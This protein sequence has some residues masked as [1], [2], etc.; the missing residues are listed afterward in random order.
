MANGT[1]FKVEGLAEIERMMK[2]LPYRNERKIKRGAL[3]AGSREIVKSIREEIDQIPG[4]ALG[5]SGKTRYKKSIGTETQKNKRS[6]AGV[7]VGARYTGAKNIFPESHLFEFGTAERTTS[8]G[9]SR[10]RIRPQPAIRTGWDR[11]KRSAV[12]V[13]RIELVERTTDEARKLLR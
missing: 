1:Y 9:A 3:R 2:R 12:D 11:S 4:D 13:T 8:A 7:F 5:R 10:G 6:E